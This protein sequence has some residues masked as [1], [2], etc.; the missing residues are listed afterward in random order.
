MAVRV[1]LFREWDP[2]GVNEHPQCL[3]EYNS[4]APAICRMLRSDVDEFKLAAHLRRLATEGMGLSRVD[5]ELHQRVARR[6]LSHFA[7]M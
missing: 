4:Y 5:E 6:L 7:D 3:D 2:I 1:I